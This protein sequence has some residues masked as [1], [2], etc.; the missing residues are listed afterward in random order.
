M[1][2][3]AHVV[4]DAAPEERD[5][6]AAAVLRVHAGA[7]RFHEPVAQRREAREVELALR[8][9]AARAPRALGREQP[10]GAQHLAGGVVPHEEVV[11]EVVEA[12]AVEA[13]LAGGEAGTHLAREHPVAQLLRLDDLARRG[14]QAHG[15]PPP[16]RARG[17]L[18]DLDLHGAPVWQSDGGR[19]G[20]PGDSPVTVA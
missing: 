5:H 10:V 3:G 8:V 15:K 16:G 12:V 9:E 6:G 11:A 14:G 7:P 13:R 4:R 18:Q 2:P 19:L 1:A 20:A 17:A